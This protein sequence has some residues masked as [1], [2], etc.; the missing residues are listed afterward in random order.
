MVA[1]DYYSSKR[2]FPSKEHI[3]SERICHRVLLVSNLV[4]AFF[5][6]KKGG[7]F[8][9]LEVQHKILGSPLAHVLK[10]RARLKLPVQMT[11]KDAALVD[12]LRTTILCPLCLE[13]IGNLYERTKEIYLAT[14]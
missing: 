3:S 9:F 11:W 7:T 4:S 13:S 8:F 14:I 6:L 1:I 12:L 2:K 10:L 5:R